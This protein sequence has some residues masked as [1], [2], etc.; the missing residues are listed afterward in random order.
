[1]SGRCQSCGMPLTKDPAGGGSEADGS[2]STLY[3]SL[4][5]EGGE[6]KQANM[7]ATEFQAFC[8]EQLK[9]KGMPGLMAW[10]FTRGI[11]KLKRW[12]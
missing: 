5:Y 1:M 2:K 9:N 4:C 7:S 12:S 8:V 3:C 6:F 11:P 10:M